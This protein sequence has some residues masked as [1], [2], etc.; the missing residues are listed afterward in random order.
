MWSFNTG[1]LSTSACFGS[2]RL[3]IKMTKVLWEKSQLIIT[4][5]RHWLSSYTENI[6]VIFFVLTPKVMYFYRV[7]EYLEIQRRKKKKEKQ[8]LNVRWQCCLDSEYLYNHI[9]VCMHM[10]ILYLYKWWF[11]LQ[12]YKSVYIKFC[13]F[14]LHSLYYRHLFM[15]LAIFI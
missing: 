5:I 6:L 3:N 13:D 11:F 15:S 4:L 10:Y 1:P 14:F 7:L 12:K 8:T 2:L 9:Y